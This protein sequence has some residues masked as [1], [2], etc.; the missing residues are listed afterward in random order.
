MRARKYLSWG[1]IV[2]V[3]SSCVRT[4]TRSTTGLEMRDCAAP[5]THQPA[6][7]GTIAVPEDPSKPGGRQIH[8][9]VLIL[10]AKDTLHKLEPIVFLHGGPGFPGARPRRD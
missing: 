8:L 7:C 4:E 1:A 9:A 3:G 5:A 10:P 6:R 2:A